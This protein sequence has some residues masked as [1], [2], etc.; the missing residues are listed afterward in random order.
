MPVA[1]GRR[2]NF[3]LEE[4]SPTPVDAGGEIVLVDQRLQFGQGPMD[5]GARHRRHQ[6]VDD[7]R[8]CAPLGLSCPRPGR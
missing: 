8:A 6:V 2:Q 3:L 4:V 5:V 7:D 1:R